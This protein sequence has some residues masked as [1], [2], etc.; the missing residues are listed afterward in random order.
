[1]ADVGHEVAA[2]GVEPAPL[3]HV[4]DHHHRATDHRHGR[5]VDGAARRPEQ[6][7]GAQVR[8]AGCRGGEHLVDGHLDE[9]LAVAGLDP[10]GR[11]RLRAITLAGGVADHHPLGDG[12]EGAQAAGAQVGREPRQV[13]EVVGGA[14]Q[15]GEARGGAG[16]V[17][18]GDRIGLLGGGRRIGGVGARAVDLAAGVGRDGQ[19]AGRAVD[20]RGEGIDAKAGPAAVEEEPRSDDGEGHSGQRRE[21]GDDGH[22]SG[23]VPLPFAEPFDSP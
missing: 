23:P 8:A 14:C 10:P 3:G 4:V 16:V 7:D 5:Q 21:N 20:A 2:H 18:R 17:Q 6:L 9:R 12:V 15:A 11:L 19:V 13:G 22:Q 1:M